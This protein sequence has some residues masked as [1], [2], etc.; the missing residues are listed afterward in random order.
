MP[1]GMYRCEVQVTLLQVSI[2]VFLFG[3]AELHCTQ[4]QLSARQPVIR[5]S[6]NQNIC[7]II[8]NLL[9]MQHQTQ[10]ADDCL[11]NCIAY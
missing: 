8:M 5:I 2:A 1:I 9:R 6:D 10:T 3:Y 4:D 11:K 7:I